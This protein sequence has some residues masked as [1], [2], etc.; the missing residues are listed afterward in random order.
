MENVHSDLVTTGLR[1]LNGTPGPVYCLQRR[2]F[3]SEV[4]DSNTKNQFQDK[5]YELQ[6]EVGTY[7]QRDH[8]KACQPR[9]GVHPYMVTAVQQSGD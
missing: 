3:H 9:D 1:E 2:T 7:A 6:L 5:L 4:S 8:T